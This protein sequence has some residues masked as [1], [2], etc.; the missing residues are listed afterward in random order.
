VQSANLVDVAPP[1]RARGALL[2]WTLAAVSLACYAAYAWTALVRLGLLDR[3]SE[4]AIGLVGVAALLALGLVSPVATSAVMLVLVP[5]VGN[6]PG[7]RLVE[8]INLP[9]A[10]S[11]AGL[12]LQARRLRMPP[13]R[14][15]I[16]I[17]AGLYAASAIVSLVPAL[18][19][20]WVRTAQ[21]N[22]WPTTIV[23]ALTAPEDNPLYSVASA[24]GVTLCVA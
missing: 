20:I 3:H 1:A 7:G 23:D 8:L 19:G 4:T 2:A 17:A 6:H 21:L 22:A 10:A 11:A 9:L 14:T 5:F 18:P 15:A 24:V 16:W 12:A 13:P